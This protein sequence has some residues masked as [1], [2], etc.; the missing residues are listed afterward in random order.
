MCFRKE[1]IE[2]RQGKCHVV[3]IDVGMTE[4]TRK[5]LTFMEEILRDIKPGKQLSQALQ[6]IMISICNNLPI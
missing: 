4:K 5:R 6:A 1:K 3:N 2:K